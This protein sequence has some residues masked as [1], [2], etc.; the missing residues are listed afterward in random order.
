MLH[1]IQ[2]NRSPGVET[3]RLTGEQARTNKTEA[4]AGLLEAAETGF[5]N[6]VR[7][8]AKD[9][10]GPRPHFRQIQCLIMSA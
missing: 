10:L 2:T 3:M 8:L 9:V 1:R 6:F 5:M 4:L 7:L